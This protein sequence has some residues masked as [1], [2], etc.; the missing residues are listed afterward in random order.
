[1]FDRN[2]GIIYLADFVQFGVLLDGDF[3]LLHSFLG[4]YIH[5]TSVVDDQVEGLA[6]TFHSSMKNISS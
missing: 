1:M 6:I 4:N 3:E 2:G 5:P